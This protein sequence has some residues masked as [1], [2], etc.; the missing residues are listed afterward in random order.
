MYFHKQGYKTQ[1]LEMLVL[2]QIMWLVW[3]GHSIVNLFFVHSDIMCGL[4]HCEAGRSAPLYG[5]DKGFST[6]NV[7]ANDMEYECKYVI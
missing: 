2:R 1:L 3:L 6:T 4:L 7:N 5:S